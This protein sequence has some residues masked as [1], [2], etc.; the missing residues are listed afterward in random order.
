M[1]EFLFF[2]LIMTGI[3]SGTIICGWMVWKNKM[4]CFWGSF[5]ITIYVFTFLMVFA[6]LADI[7]KGL[8]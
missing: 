8:K 2:Y 3:F 5:K 7:L 4:P 6:L 1:F